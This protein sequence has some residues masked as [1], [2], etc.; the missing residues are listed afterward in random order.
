MSRDDQI[1]AIKANVE[2]LWQDR[3]SECSEQIMA[4]Y[5]EASVVAE[6]ANLT[7]ESDRSPSGFRVFSNSE[8][9]PEEHFQDSSYHWDF[10]CKQLGRS[11]ALAEEGYIFEELSGLSGDSEP[12]DASNPDLQL[13][14][15]GIGELVSRGFEPSALVA[16]IE[17]YHP[18]LVF[19]GFNI[20]IAEGRYIE[21]PRGL[22]LE[23]FWSSNLRP[24][25]RFVVLDRKAGTWTVKPDP[26]TGERLT[27]AI[28]RPESPPK[29][30][31]FLAET[32]V[33][34]EIDDRDGFYVVEVVGEPPKE[35][36]L[37]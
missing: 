34:Y 22:R 7:E 17:L 35:L 5:S 26:E 12:I 6:L 1:A 36:S 2:G 27:V 32:I 21:L 4:G 3:L 16:P 25:N 37:Q 29:A 9:R 28:G 33:R 20:D 31:R 30:V 10:Y 19:N 24:M 23:L 14:L 15:T 13:V 8:N 18:V 11:I